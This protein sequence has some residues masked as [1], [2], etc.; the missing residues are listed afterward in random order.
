MLIIE[1]ASTCVEIIFGSIDARLRQLKECPT[2][3]IIGTH[4]PC[5]DNW[6]QL[7]LIVGPKLFTQPSP[8]A[9]IQN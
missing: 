5:Y 3:T 9:F 6:L 8:N 1:E 7:G 2:I 4:I